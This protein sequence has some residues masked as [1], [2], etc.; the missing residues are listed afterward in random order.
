MLGPFDCQNL[1]ELDDAALAGAIGGPQL[2]PHKAHLGADIDDLS[3]ALRDHH[4]TDLLGA[5]EQAFQIDI[6]E[7]IPMLLGDL[8][9]WLRDVD[10]C[11][12]YKDVN[13][14]KALCGR[15]DHS[16]DTLQRPDLQIQGQ[17]FT[18]H[19]TDLGR[20]RLSTIQGTTGDDDVGASIGQCQGN[21]IAEAFAGA[22]DNGDLVGQPE[23]GELHGLPPNRLHHL[24]ASGICRLLIQDGDR[25]KWR[26]RPFANLEG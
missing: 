8:Q 24:P 11:V 26:A 5:E 7:A 12:A 18:A 1:G 6:H 16:I 13:P 9:S 25:P 19:F 21:T 14:A 20:H 15:L 3:L 17:S 22:C 4:L 10:A 23:I 2:P